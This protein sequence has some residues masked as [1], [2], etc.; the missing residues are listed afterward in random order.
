MK[1]ENCF[2]I[3]NTKNLKEKEGGKLFFL[4]IGSKRTLGIY[5]QP[6]GIIG[7]PPPHPPLHVINGGPLTMGQSSYKRS[8][9]SHTREPDELKWVLTYCSYVS[10]CLG[11][12][13]YFYLHPVL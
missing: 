13:R 10:S 2:T 6:A 7:P 3:K 4:N 5:M 12:L 11:V 9:D 1:D 8:K